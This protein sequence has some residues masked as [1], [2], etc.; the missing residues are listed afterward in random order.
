[1]KIAFKIIILALFISGLINACT[2]KAD[3]ITGPTGPQGPAG[4]DGQY[5][6]S[7]VTGYVNAYNQY[8]MPGLSNAGINVSTKKGDSIISAVSGSTGKFS[9]PNLVPGNY[10]LLFKKDG[11]DS[12]KVYVVHSGGDEDKFIGIVNVNASL[13]TKITSV[14]FNYTSSPFPN[15]TNLVLLLNVN[16]DGPPE[17]FDTRRDFNVYF[18][19]SISV[20]SG[21]YD[22]YISSTGNGALTNNNQYPFSYPLIN[23][24]NSGY[25]YNKGDTVYVK[26]CIV[27]VGSA[28]TSWFDYA[29]Y[30]TIS[31]PYKGDSL[32]NY[33]IWPQ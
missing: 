24:I 8:G 2:K 9:L 18:S 16:F 33:F 19:K 5:K 27:P 21:N 29:T 25:H 11:Y 12:L 3:G 10:D 6:A 17:T 26:T 30:K 23:F 28:L 15:D 7:A 13:T 31:Y 32:Q 4:A 14:D 22:I 1:M 20:S